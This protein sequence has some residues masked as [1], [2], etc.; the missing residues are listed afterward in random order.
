MCIIRFG[1]ERS[2]FLSLTL[3]GRSNPKA[4][5]YWDGNWLGC[6]VEVCCGAFR[7]D[8]DSMIRNEDLA[9]F[10]PA[11]TR[12]YEGLSGEASFDTLEGWIDFKLI[13]DGRGHI[14]LRGRLVDAMMDGNSLEFRIGFDQTYLPAIIS[15][16]RT[17][18]ERFPVVGR[19]EGPRS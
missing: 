18:T 6:K 11:L 8:L 5:D 13:G 14:E 19:P 9:A 16:V 2:E 12:L 10:L 17:A 7:G 3:H 4:D 15:Q 1:G